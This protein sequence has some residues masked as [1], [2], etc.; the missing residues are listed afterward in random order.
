M[1]SQSTFLSLDFYTRKVNVTKVNISLLP[2][3]LL[4]SPLLQR[5]MEME[6]DG[7]DGGTEIERG[8]RRNTRGGR[9]KR[10]REKIEM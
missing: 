8:G 4:F 5:A 6:R 10:G 3:F 1:T 9:R 2:L 7:G